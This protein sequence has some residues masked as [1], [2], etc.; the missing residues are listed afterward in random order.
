MLNLIQHPR[1]NVSHWIPGHQSPTFT[2]YCLPIIVFKHFIVFHT[3]VMYTV[4]VGLGAEPGMT[5]KKIKTAQRTQC[6]MCG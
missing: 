6:V 5:D 2:K 4:K 1:N 3:R